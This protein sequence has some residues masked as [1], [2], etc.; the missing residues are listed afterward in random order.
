MDV[1]GLGFE[2]GTTPFE[3][4]PK[5]LEFPSRFGGLTEAVCGTGDRFETA[6]SAPPWD[7]VDMEAYALAK[8]C[9]FEQVPF[10]CAKYVTDGADENAGSHW[11]AELEAA[12][13]A[14]VRL[15]RELVAAP[16]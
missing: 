13:R 10:A 9:W 11:E 5:E 15:Y 16:L 2:P 4:V 8:V 6:I 3:E 12:A 14:F 1:S 7:L